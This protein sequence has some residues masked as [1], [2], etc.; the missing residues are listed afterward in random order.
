M[1]RQAKLSPNGFTIIEL[2]IVLAIIAILLAMAVPAYQDYAI[3]SKL[4]ECI[5]NSMVA[6]TQL[7]HLTGLANVA[8]A[9]IGANLEGDKVKAVIASQITG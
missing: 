1:Y 7:H 5:S 4:T 3:R 9:L 8:S 2:M 6:K